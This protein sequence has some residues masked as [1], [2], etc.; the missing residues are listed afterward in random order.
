MQLFREQVRPSCTC[1][2]PYRRP[3]WPD[4]FVKK[5][6]QN[7]AQPIFGKLNVQL[8]PWKKAALSYFC[9]FKK[10]TQRKQSPC[11]RKFAQSGHPVYDEALRRAV[12]F[13]FVHSQISGRQV[14][15]TQP[16]T[17]M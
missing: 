10:S 4:E 7:V 17:K 11:R 3:G 13:W 12:S 1:A 15:C 6:A 14:V 5:F 9:I 16:S 2:K 8:L